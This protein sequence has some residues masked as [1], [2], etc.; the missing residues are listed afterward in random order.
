MIHVR[1]TEAFPASGAE[2][3]QAKQHDRVYAPKP[4]VNAVSAEIK[5]CS[6][7]AR[8]FVVVFDYGLGSTLSRGGAQV[9]GRY[10][11]PVP[12]RRPGC[13]RCL[14]KRF[15]SILDHSMHN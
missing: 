12:C 14:Y 7:S 11:N 8:V 10:T 9:C 13:S 2:L 3:S 4:A 1:R 5:N 6:L 15:D